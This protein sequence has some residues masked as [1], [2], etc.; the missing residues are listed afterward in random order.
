MKWLGHLFHTGKK[1]DKSHFKYSRKLF[2][3]VQ[4]LHHF[5]TDPRVSA[6]HFCPWNHLGVFIWRAL[7]GY[8]IF[9]L[10]YGIAENK[11]DAG[12][13]RSTFGTRHCGPVRVHLIIRE[14]SLSLNIC[15][16]G[17]FLRCFGSCNEADQDIELRVQGTAC[18]LYRL[19]RSP[20]VSFTPYQS[21]NQLNGVGIKN[22]GVD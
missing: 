18:L 11:I 16:S 2:V 7:I 5:D 21:R 15:R 12:S 22:Q 8:R 13:D 4:L 6:Q 1:I 10:V 20:F 9:H 17:Y 3:G 19:P 14:Y